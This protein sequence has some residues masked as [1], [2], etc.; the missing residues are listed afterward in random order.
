MTGRDV[1]LSAETTSADSLE[2]RIMGFEIHRLRSVTGILGLLVCS[3]TTSSCESSHRSTIVAEVVGFRNGRTCVVS[4]PTDVRYEGASVRTG[5]Y[6]PDPKLSTE[7]A[8]GNCVE[9]GLAYLLK[10][11]TE[12]MAVKRVLDRTCDVPEAV[13]SCLWD[14]MRSGEEETGV[15]PVAKWGRASPPCSALK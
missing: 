5:C 4:E 15:R 2:G 7:L 11:P 6:L 12:T 3:L 14:H 9:V 10:W 1:F 13:V 8:S